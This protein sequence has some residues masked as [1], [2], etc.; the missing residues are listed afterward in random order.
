MYKIHSRGDGGSEECDERPDWR[1][2]L[3]V[4]PVGFPEKLKTW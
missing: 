4:E 3:K 2:I 1:H